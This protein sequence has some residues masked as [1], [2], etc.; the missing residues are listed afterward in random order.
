MASNTNLWYI[1][2]TGRSLLANN[3]N[4]FNSTIDGNNIC[5]TD[6]NEIRM[7]NFHSKKESFLN[8]NFLNIDSPIYSLNCDD[9]WLWFSNRKGISF[10]KWSNY[11]N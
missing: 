8:L 9:E 11:E 1:D 10:F 4:D 2:I 5:A 6:F 3:I 7:I